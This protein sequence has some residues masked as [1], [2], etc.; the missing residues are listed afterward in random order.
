MFQPAAATADQDL[1]WVN[2]DPYAVRFA[3]VGAKGEPE[4]ALRLAIRLPAPKAASS[5]E[6]FV[7]SLMAASSRR[8][9]W[10]LRRAPTYWRI[11]PLDI[12]VFRLCQRTMAS[13]RMA[14][15]RAEWLIAPP[16]AAAS[17]GLALYFQPAPDA[18]FVMLSSAAA[19]LAEES[20]LSCVD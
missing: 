1:D 15:A 11:A 19:W 17:P 2:A 5:A 12:P 7:L 9:L 4:E 16:F 18:P 8:T 13:L 3:A 14:K 6:T 20:L 10:T